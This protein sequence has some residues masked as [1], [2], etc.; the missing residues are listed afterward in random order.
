MSVKAVVHRK[1]KKRVGKGFSREELISVGLSIKEA[2]A[3]K[4]P[5]DVRRRT[6]HEEN[7]ETLKNFLC[8]LSRKLKRWPK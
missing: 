3:L 4:I 6:K 1:K 7:V 5:V 2:L 8:S